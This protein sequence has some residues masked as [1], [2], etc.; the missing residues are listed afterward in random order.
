[1][2]ARNAHRF[3]VRTS[4]SVEDLC[5]PVG[6]KDS[7]EPRDRGILSA[8][9]QQT[10]VK[11]ARDHRSRSRPGSFAD[12]RVSLSFRVKGRIDDDRA[13]QTGQ[14][15]LETSY[16]RKRCETRV[17]VTVRLEF[18]IFSWESHSPRC[19]SCYEAGR[20]ARGAHGARFS[21]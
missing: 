11:L 19:K 14:E 9:V 17:R 2:L 21:A 18:F 7:P 13:R 10:R 8:K 16:T 12:P 6:L 3:L 20:P 5:F 4:R 1:M 15:N